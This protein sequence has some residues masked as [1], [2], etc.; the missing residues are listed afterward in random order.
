MNNDW[1]VWAGFNAFH[2]DIFIQSS[3]RRSRAHLTNIL[4]LVFLRQS[5]LPM[6]LKILTNVETIIVRK[7]QESY[8]QHT[9]R[10]FEEIRKKTK[11]L[12]LKHLAR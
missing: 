4:F 6:D 9:K 11:A 1:A 2:I 12:P 8:V 10:F 7:L 5:V 3:D